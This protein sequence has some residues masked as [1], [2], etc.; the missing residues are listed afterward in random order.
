MLM[1]SRSFQRVQPAIKQLS[2]S[3]ARDTLAHKTP[4]DSC[5]QPPPQ[6][7]TTTSPQWRK[8]QPL[9]PLVQQRVALLDGHRAAQ[10]LGA[11]SRQLAQRRA[12]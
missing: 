3:L 12:G 4:A 2:V 6:K 7:K 11:L 8:R 9:V 5:A 1:Q 10:L